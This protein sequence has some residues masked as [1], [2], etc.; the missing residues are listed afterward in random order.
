MLGRTAWQARKELLDDD[1][2]VH[3][4]LVSHP[5]RAPSEATVPRD[6][7]LKLATSARSSA[8]AARCPSPP[9]SP[10]LL[11]TER[12]V[13]RVRLQACRG[14]VDHTSQPQARV[15]QSAKRSGNV[16]RRC[17]CSRRDGPRQ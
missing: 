6:T 3:D 16:G 5:G 8:C 15:P 9:C 12:I 10:P 13:Y 14:V 2:D 11:L 17:A 1:D 7:P 4:T